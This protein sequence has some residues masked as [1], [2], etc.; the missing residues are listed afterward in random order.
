MKGRMSSAEILLKDLKDNLILALGCTE[1]IAIALASCKAAEVLGENVTRLTLDLSGNIIKNARSVSIPNAE[2]MKGIEAAAAL[3]VVG[4]DSSKQLEV[5]SHIGTENVR[6]ARALIPHITVNL[7]RACP[8]VYVAATAFGEHHQALVKIADAHT[9]ICHIEKDG[10]VLL[11][12]DLQTYEDNADTA[13]TSIRDIYDFATTVDLT[14]IPDITALLDKE[15]SCNYDIACCGMKENYGANVGK[16]ILASQ[17]PDDVNVLVKA[18]AAAGSDAR[19][20]GCSMPVMINSGSG[21]QGMT[22]SVPVI[23]Y[24]KH[25][26]ID[27]ERLYRA[28]ILSNLLAIHQ[29]KFIGKLSAFCGVVSAAAASGAAIGYLQ[30]MPFEKIA[31]II[32]ATVATTGGMVCDGAKASCAS[33]ISMAVDN[34]LLAVEMA[35]RGHR[36]EAGDG[37]VCENIDDTITNVG[38]MAKKGMKGTDQEI[39]HMMIGKDE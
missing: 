9:N 6:E 25:Q 22:V 1:P 29:K 8:E 31:D 16:T 12:A 32:T 15:I 17:N 3:G 10:E 14:S 37:I 38:R 23:V 34:S 21:N 19:M 18:Y 5:L 13:K 28:L 24:A 7:E 39:I 4:G 27:A 33:K 36:L 11:K 35:K 2:G 30:G 20:G 26:G